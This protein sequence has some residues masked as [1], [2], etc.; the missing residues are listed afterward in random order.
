MTYMREKGW[1][2]KLR[3]LGIDAPTEMW[4]SSPVAYVPLRLLCAKLGAVRP[5]AE[6]FESLA[7]KNTTR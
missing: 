5:I 6:L 4:L 7:V 3:V 2:V 1:F